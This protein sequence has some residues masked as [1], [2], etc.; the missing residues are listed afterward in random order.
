MQVSIA[1]KHIID[2]GVTSLL[3][4]D[5]PGWRAVFGTGKP[6]HGGR[7]LFA[8]VSCKFVLD[9]RMRLQHL[10]IVDD[11]WADQYPCDT[12]DLRLL[13]ITEGRVRYLRLGAIAQP[14]LRELAKRWCRW[15]LA[16]G[17]SPDT[18]GGNLAGVADFAAHLHIHHGHNDG[19]D[20]SARGGPSDLTRE[21]IESW[22]A[23]G[24]RRGHI[25]G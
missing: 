23:G 14:W 11:P 18:V 13:G 21:R 8:S 5:E 17:L 16:R 22:L 20:G 15:R 1:V 10:L 7:R 2:S 4:L 6:I 24:R 3:D 9:T 12:W 19:H 25:G